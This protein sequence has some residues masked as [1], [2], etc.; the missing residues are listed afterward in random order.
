LILI[1]HFPVLLISFWNFSRSF[2]LSAALTFLL[3]SGVRS[4]LGKS[5]APAESLDFQRTAQ[6]CELP[7]A[8]CTF[9]KLIHFRY[10]D[11]MY[12]STSDA[13]DVVMSLHV[14][15]VACSIMQQGYLACLT[16]L[17]KLFQNPMDGGPGYV[18]V[19]AMQCRIYLVGARV[20]LGCEKGSYDCKPLGRDGNS[21]LTTPRNEFPESLNRVA[22]MPLTTHQPEFSH[23]RALTDHQSERHTGREEVKG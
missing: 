22:L 15:V 18:R 7:Q 14:A 20:V 11:V 17:A 4:P 5:A 1:F 13:E 6:Q 10:F 16:R 19:G 12:P 2:G 3:A 23:S 21:S 8:E 9:E